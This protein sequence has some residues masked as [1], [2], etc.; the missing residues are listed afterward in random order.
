MK[1]SESLKAV[2]KLKTENI[3]E[4][5][6]LKNPSKTALTVLGGCVIMFED[7]IKSR[8]REIIMRKIEGT[9]KKE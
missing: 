2:D 9:I 5:K 1:L 4:I 6:A 7:I 8:G 3:V